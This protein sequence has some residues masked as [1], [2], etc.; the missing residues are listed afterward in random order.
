MIEDHDKSK[1]LFLYM[2]Y[3]APHGPIMKPPEKYLEMY[4]ELGRFQNPGDQKKLNRAATI[5]VCALT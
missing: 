3:Q 2:A 4:K 1:P 5:T